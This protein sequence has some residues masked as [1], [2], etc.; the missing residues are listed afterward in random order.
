MLGSINSCV[1]CTVLDVVYSIYCNSCLLC[2]IAWK[3]EGTV[4]WLLLYQYSAVI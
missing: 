4:R 2:N 3:D 1:S